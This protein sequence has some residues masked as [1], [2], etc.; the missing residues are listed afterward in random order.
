M[1]ATD[2]IGNRCSAETRSDRG[3]RRK[4]LWARATGREP[5]YSGPTFCNPFVISWGM[6][7]R[8]QPALN[9]N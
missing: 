4:G 5:P 3:A 6:A 2:L 9:I 7:P 1:T 8:D